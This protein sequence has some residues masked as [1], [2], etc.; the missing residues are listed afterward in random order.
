MDLGQVCAKDAAGLF[1]ALAQAESLDGFYANRTFG[2][3]GF[4]VWNKDHL[5]LGSGIEIEYSVEDIANEN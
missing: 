5:W 3:E 1:Y 4:L 2:K